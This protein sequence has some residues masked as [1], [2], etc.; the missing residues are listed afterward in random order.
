MELRIKR[1]RRW[2]A[3]G[4][5]RPRDPA[6]YGLAAPSVLPPC[7]LRGRGKCSPCTPSLAATART[8]FDSRADNAAFFCLRRGLGLKDGPGSARASTVSV[9]LRSRFILSPS[10]RPSPSTRRVAYGERMN[11]PGEGGAFAPIPRRR[12]APGGRAPR[13]GGP[14][15]GSRPRTPRVW[16]RSPRFFT[17]YRPTRTRQDLPAPAR[18]NPAPHS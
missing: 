14:R 7:V 13:E 3:P 1:S 10:A 2:R 5:R 18:G 15:G 11:P 16:L 4:A 12:R 6:I 8:R 17:P 9:W